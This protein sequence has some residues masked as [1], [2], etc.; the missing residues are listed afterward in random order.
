ML[1][2]GGQKPGRVAPS[3][4]AHLE[5]LL[6]R[7]RALPPDEEVAWFFGNW[8]INAPL[9]A[10]LSPQ[11]RADAVLDL[12]ETPQFL[13][14]AG[15]YLNG[16]SQGSAM[17][18]STGALAGAE[19][20]YG[21]ID[22]AV[23]LCRLLADQLELRMPGAISEMSP[24]GGCFVQ[25]WSGY[26]AIY[27]L[28]CGVFGLFPDAGARH[29]VLAPQLPS[30]WPYARLTDIRVGDALLSLELARGDTGRVVCR[31]R[32][33]QPGWRITFLARLSATESDSVVRTAFAIHAALTDDGWGLSSAVL[34]HGQT[35]EL[36]AQ[37]T[38]EQPI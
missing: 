22:Q 2:P 34:H 38:W 32:M 13:G 5:S 28:A 19:I 15:V 35:V 29:V 18:I 8:V 17:S 27:P 16:I 24:D 31:A 20:A 21:R 11:G 30:G 25:A 10:G 9:E 26:G 6:Q 23:R 33:D 37:Q 12:L 4:L 7:A 14:P 36:P 3:M 1:R